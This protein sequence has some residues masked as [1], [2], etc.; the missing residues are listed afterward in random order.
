MRVREAAPQEAD[1]EQFTGK[2]QYTLRVD[3]AAS[4]PS[5]SSS[6]GV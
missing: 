2:T 5:S 6:V 4:S 1:E 3:L